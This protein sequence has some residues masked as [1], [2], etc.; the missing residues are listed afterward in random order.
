[1]YV[2]FW[3][4]NFFDLTFKYFFGPNRGCQKLAAAIFATQVAGKLN[5]IWEMKKLSSYKQ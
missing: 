3:R 5:P 4:R 2:I 1:M